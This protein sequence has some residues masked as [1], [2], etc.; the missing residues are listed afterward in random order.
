MSR[1]RETGIWWVGEAPADWAVAPVRSRFEV[2]LGKMVDAARNEGTETRPYLRNVNVQWGRFDLG[3]VNEMQFTDAECTQYELRT[4]DILVCEGGEVGRAAIWQSEL[5]GCLYQKALHRLRPN[6]DVDARFFFYALNAAASLGVFEAE[7]SQSTI[8]HLTAEKLRAHRF[9][10]PQVAEQ[11]AIADYLDTE[12]ARID[13]LITKKRR[14]I[15][16]LEEQLRAAVVDLA[17]GRND[18]DHTSSGIGWIGQ[19]PGEWSIRR[20]SHISRMGTGHTP[21]KSKPEWWQDCTTPWVSLNDVA[22]MAHLEFI[23]DTRNKISDLGLANSSA[24]VHPAGIV[25][26]SRDATV[27]RCAI[28]EVPMAVSQHFVTWACGPLIRPRYLYLLLAFPMQAL[29]DSFNDGATLRTIGMP[30]LQALKV[31]LPPLEVQDRIVE[32][33]SRRRTTTASLI[34]SSTRQ[35]DLLAERRQALITAAVT[36][37]LA[38]PGVAA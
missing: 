3:D 34:D 22:D 19:V 28:A 37:Q 6:A 4:N 23:S 21:S 9:V 10:W 7:G 38:I 13:A 11:R 1:T 2:Q 26:L 35:L 30:H 16:L 36:G 31:P 32:E 17:M 12:T 14:M 18:S 27:G 15:E 29:F 33:A 5:E 8:L 25:M 20:L 24:V